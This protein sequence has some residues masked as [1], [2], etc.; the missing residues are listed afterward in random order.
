MTA[1][2]RISKGISLLIVLIAMTL[3]LAADSGNP[4]YAKIK[5]NYVVAQ[6]G[7]GTFKTVKQAID[8][9]PDN[10]STRTFIYVKNGI[11]RE[12]I[13]IAAAKTNVSLLG[14]DMMKT[15]ITYDN[16]AENSAMT[17]KTTGPPEARRSL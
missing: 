14:E 2:S 5:F 4:A 3:S 6:D 7:S 12:N 11:Y 8:A 1:T 13:T 9:V 16:Y 15:V 17:G 10:L